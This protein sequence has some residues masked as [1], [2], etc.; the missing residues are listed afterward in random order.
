MNIYLVHEKTFM[1]EKTVAVCNNVSELVI[2]LN[3]KEFRDK[4]KGR[5]SV[6]TVT[7]IE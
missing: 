7:V 4:V 3:S 2:M 6:E 5:L 1:K